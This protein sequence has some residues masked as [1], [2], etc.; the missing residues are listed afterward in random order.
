MWVDGSSGDEKSL[1][2]LCYRVYREL[3]KNTNI[4]HFESVENY[5]KN[6][7]TR[8]WS[9]SKEE[10]DFYNDL[11][12]KYNNKNQ[13]QDDFY[14]DIIQNQ[15]NKPEVEPQSFRNPPPSSTRNA[16]SGPSV[17]V[18]TNN[19]Q[20]KIFISLILMAISFFLLIM[21]SIFHGKTIGNYFFFAIVCIITIINVIKAKKD[22]FKSV[23]S[24]KRASTFNLII[25]LLLFL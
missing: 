19:S 18:K 6:A 23:K 24:M 14:A 8:S 13:A 17:S 16:A 4:T 11:I 9:S 12:R 10:D 15:K 20:L 21:T 25:A 7:N 3:Q 1:Y 2:E 5:R 22:T